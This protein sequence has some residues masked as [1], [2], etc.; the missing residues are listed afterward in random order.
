LNLG[1][2]MS[3]PI[4]LSLVDGGDESKSHETIWLKGDEFELRILAN[5]PNLAPKIIESL[6]PKFPQEI[7]S[8]GV[9]VNISHQDSEFLI[10]L[11]LNH[12][13]AVS[14]VRLS[15]EWAQYFMASEVRLVAAAAANPTLPSEYWRYCQCH[16]DKSIRQN[17]AINP[18][19]GYATLAELSGDVDPLVAAV[20]AGQIQRRFPAVQQPT[21]IQPTNTIALTNPAN[22]SNSQQT[23]KKGAVQ[24]TVEPLHLL[25]AGLSIALAVMTALLLFRS[26]QQTVLQPQ[27]SAA[28]SGASK[29]ASTEDTNFSLAIERA[30]EA[31]ALARTSPEAKSDWQTIVKNWDEAITLLEKVGKDDPDFSK[32]QKKIRTYKIIRS[33]AAGNA[34]KVN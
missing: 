12:I 8:S 20:A 10:R 1:N 18:M 23:T 25:I 31:T 9:L 6:F 34:E 7:M 27:G 22:F 21:Q 11:F 30:N 29:A 28:V 19:V 24:I 13:Q 32:A 4:R 5:E 26:P 3:D 33:V 14:N 17:I 15:E 2:N 16:Y